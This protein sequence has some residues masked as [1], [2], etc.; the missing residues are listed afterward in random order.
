MSAR[1]I[2]APLGAWL[3]AAIDIQPYLTVG[4]ILLALV[5]GWR[6]FKVRDFS[7]EIQGLKSALNTA[8]VVKKT[9]DERRV[10][11]EEQLRGAQERA[12]VAEKLVEALQE[13]LREWRKRYDEK[14][15]GTSLQEVQGVLI[16][17]A[18]NQDKRH[19]EMMQLMARLA[20]EK[21]VEK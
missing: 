6:A 18:Q 20:G 21:S 19:Q 11:L 13:E 14:A 7:G 15:A 8:E 2:A 1:V 3:L 9:D 10:Q 16:K 4:G 17:M 5:L 12:N